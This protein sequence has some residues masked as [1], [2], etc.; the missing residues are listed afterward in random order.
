MY[1]PFL[2]G[3]NNIL[4]SAV[5][6]TTFF[7]YRHYLFILFPATFPPQKFIFP[8][9]SITEHQIVSDCNIRFISPHYIE[10]QIT[11]IKLVYALSC[12]V[13]AGQVSVYLEYASM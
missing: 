7:K 8:C 6:M 3:G 2:V 11:K 1:D 9:V 13:A 5:A 4:T 12:K 10:L